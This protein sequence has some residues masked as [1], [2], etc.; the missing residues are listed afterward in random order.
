MQHQERIW[1]LLGKKLAGEATGDELQELEELL[2]RSP[3]VTYSAGILSEL[4]QQ[5]KTPGRMEKKE[6][7]D[8]FD[9]HLQRMAQKNA[10]SAAQEGGPIPEYEQP[11]PWTRPGGAKAWLAQNLQTNG[12]LNSYFKSAWRNLS[13]NKVFSVINISGLAIGMASAILI[14]I[15]I[16]REMGVD[17]FHAQRDRTYAVLN[18]SVSEGKT[19][20]WSSTPHLLAPTLKASYPTLVDQ[21]LRIN[22]VGAFAFSVGNRF[23]ETHGYITDPNYL[24]IFSFPLLQGDPATVLSNERSVVITESLARKL[25]DDQ[26]AMGKLIRVDTSGYFYVS[27]ILKDLPDNTSQH[28]EYLLPWSYMKDVGWNSEVW[29]HNNISTVVTLQPGVSEAAAGK[30]FAGI[31]QAN[32][33]TVPNQPYLHPMRKWYLW[34]QFDNGVSVGGRIHI[35]RLFGII[36]AFIL[37]IAC[38]NYMNLSTARSIKRA[39]E[40]GIRK[41]VG[42]G[43]SSL[44]WQFLGE[45]ILI[46]AVA[47]A[48]ALVLLFPAVKGFNKLVDSAIHIPWN[49]PWAWLT[50]LGFILFTG[51]IAGSYP[52]FFLAGYRPVSVIKGSFKAARTF[53]T[54]RK[55]LVVVQFTFAI[56][57]II[58]SIIIYRQV[59]HG[60]QRDVGY[61]RN[62]LAFI[63]NKGNADKH[64]AEL[65][66]ALLNSGAVT[67][68]TRISAPITEVWNTTDGFQWAGKDSSQR[69]EF[70][71]YTADDDYIKTI[72]LQ[73]VAGRDFNRQQF[74]RDTAAVII[75]ETAAR[76]TGFTRPLGQTL[77]MGPHRWTI[78]GIVKDFIPHSPYSRPFPICVLGPRDDLNVYGAVHFRFNPAHTDAENLATVKD[79][80]NRINPG[81][82][83]A[84]HYVNEAF[85]VK[86]LDEKRMGALAFIFAGLTVLISCLGL[87]ALAI[88]MAENRTKEIGVRKVLGA[89][90][91]A[92]TT[93]LSKD[94]LKLVLISFAIASPLAW[95]FMHSWLQQFDYHVHISWWIFVL[96]GI[97]SVFIA[98]AT[99]IQQSIKAALTNPI[100][101]LRAE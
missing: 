93:L 28:F 34:S 90:V 41:V 44:V 5:E 82:P 40:V 16:W 2:R 88:Y 17:Q 35:V 13:R 63:Y 78:I 53:M 36:A 80:Y 52:A 31:I 101:A 79:I 74:A 30:A 100:N 11:F 1:H 38:I 66:S 25:F 65:K 81:F 84:Y 97:L 61:N 72:G 71:Q 3:D 42:A 83:I 4:W 89:S 48:I 18:S 32:D 64:Y 12:K 98:I 75:N 20:T 62:E 14:L 85:A 55:V 86:V 49:N 21:T 22:W 9:R 60:L 8:A 69:R 59:R 68:V 94:F 95:W 51:I 92:I 33:P 39:R 19:Y 46:S 70:F 73:L 29:G 58:C 47:G 27:G 56:V 26:P 10:D 54:P 67:S 50:A 45:S 37:L 99:V 87:Y 15:W 43:K 7:E 96:T 6:V 23:V 77:Q 24:S 76:Q 91:A 57:L